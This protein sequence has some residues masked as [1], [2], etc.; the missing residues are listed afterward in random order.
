V[1]GVIEVASGYVG[2]QTENPTYREVC[3]DR[4]GHAEVVRVEFDPE[5]VSYS[6]LLDAFWKMHDPTQRNR[7]GPD[8]GTQY[9][10]VIFTYSPE[11][12]RAARE[13][14]ARSRTIGPVFAANCD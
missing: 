12:E 4:T 11:Q 13:S 10:S 6:S 9:R 8:V 14:K 3:T 7:Q 5:R 1:P 2:G